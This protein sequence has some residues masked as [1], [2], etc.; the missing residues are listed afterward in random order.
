MKKLERAH[1]ELSSP[2]LVHNL[3][4]HLNPYWDMACQVA[5]KYED[6]LLIRKPA[7]DI[8]RIIISLRCNVC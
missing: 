7:H 5:E 8:S 6:S 3:L 4:H 2:T 1:E